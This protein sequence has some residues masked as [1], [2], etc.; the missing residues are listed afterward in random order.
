M[1]TTAA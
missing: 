1:Y